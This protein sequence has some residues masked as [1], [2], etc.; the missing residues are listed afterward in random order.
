MPLAPQF[1]W[2][3]TEATLEVTVD[4]PG[5]SRAKADVFA[6]DAFL[7]VNCPPYLFALDLFMDVDDS[8][9]SATIIPGAVVFKLFKVY[10]LCAEG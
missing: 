7:K 3:E 5:V 10:A 9:S 4:V 2:L 8:R 1:K 6:T